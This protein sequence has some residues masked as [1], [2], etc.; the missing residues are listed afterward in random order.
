MKLQIV[1]NRK[2]YIQIADQ[3]RDQIVAGAVEPGQ[4]LP[5]E[6]DLA[7]SLGVSRPTV[8]EALIAL[9]VAGLVEVRVGVG[10]FVRKPAANADK[11][12]ELSRSPIEIMTVR[13]MLEPEAAALASQQIDAAGRKRLQSIL[14]Q[15]RNETAEGHWSTDTDRS[16]HLTLADAAGN[17]VLREMLETLWTMREE[18]MDNRFHQHLADIGDVREH[19]LADHEAIVAAIVA[20]DADASRGAMIA[21]LDYVSKAMVEAW[22]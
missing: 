2:L 17:T 8:R 4:Q 15:M 7:T 6:R 11:L 5:S 9:E 19:I 18:A 12:P 21:H 20:G 13:R 1:T 14:R 10:A 16:L 22:E 3:I